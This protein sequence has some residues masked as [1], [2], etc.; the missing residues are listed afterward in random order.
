MT[1]GMLILMLGLFTIPGLVFV[2][3][4]HMI[5]SWIKEHRRK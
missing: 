4:I 5:V 1:P 2:Y 3:L